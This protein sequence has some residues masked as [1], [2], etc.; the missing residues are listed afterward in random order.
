MKKRNTQHTAAAQVAPR[1]PSLAAVARR[2]LK[3]MGVEKR[4]QAEAAADTATPADK[5]TQLK[6]TGLA[7]ASLL[8]REQVI[9]APWYRGDTRLCVMAFTDGGGRCTGLELVS[10]G[11]PK[12]LGIL[13]SEIMRRAVRAEADG[14]VL[15]ANAGSDFRADEKIWQNLDAIGDPLNIRVHD[16]LTFHPFDA[17][18]GAWSARE[19]SI[20]RVETARPELQHDPLNLSGILLQ[21]TAAMVADG[22]P[23]ALAWTVAGYHGV[24]ADELPGLLQKYG[25]WLPAELYGAFSRRYR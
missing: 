21:R 11:T 18:R 4:T 7:D 9:T 13:P 16:L 10:T 5:P 24:F 8:W 25:R 14:I 23:I 12:S 22:V 19:S 1:K 6:I 3:A 17:M 15:M 2:E 20:Q